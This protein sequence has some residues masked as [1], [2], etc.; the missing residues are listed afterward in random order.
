MASNEGEKIRDFWKP[1][2]EINRINE[3]HIRKAM[4]T[5]DCE[6]HSI[7]FFLYHPVYKPHRN[8]VLKA[9]KLKGS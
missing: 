1:K 6:E 4:K 2:N 7:S 3:R 5:A 9:L 8:K